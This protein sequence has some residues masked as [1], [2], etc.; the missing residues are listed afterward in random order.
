MK[1]WLTSPQGLILL[2]FVAAVLLYPLFTTLDPMA[3]AMMALVVGV[4]I[5]AGRRRLALRLLK[6]EHRWDA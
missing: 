2:L 3:G 6:S 5:S 4:A 1:F